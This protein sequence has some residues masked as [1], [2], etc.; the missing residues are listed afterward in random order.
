MSGED[1]KS[2]TEELQERDLR[3]RKWRRGPLGDT[4]TE[5][6]QSVVRL[7]QQQQRRKQSRKSGGSDIRF[8]LRRI[9]IRLVVEFGRFPARISRFVDDDG[10]LPGPSIL[11]VDP[12]TDRRKDGGYIRRGEA[13][14]P[15]QHYEPQ[16]VARER[17]LPDRKIQ[18]EKH[19]LSPPQTLL[20][21]VQ[22][23]P[24]AAAGDR[25]ACAVEQSDIERSESRLDS[26]EGVGCRC[27]S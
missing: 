8:R 9:D 15:D 16:P 25:R 2:G 26:E 7:Q 4:G 24:E 11:G 6:R 21:Q 1:R 3:L 5:L 12:A 10:G 13:L 23:Q 20:F 18:I 17:P 14:Q 22:R 19:G 27:Q